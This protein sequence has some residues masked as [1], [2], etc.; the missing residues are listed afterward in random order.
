MAAGAAVSLTTQEDKTNQDGTSLQ[1][2]ECLLLIGTRQD[3]NAFSELYDHYAPRLNGYLIKQGA[4]P[5]MAEELS[6]EALLAVWNKASSYNAKLASPN[7]WIFTIARNLLIDHYRRKSSKNTEALEPYHLDE[8]H[9]DDEHNGNEIGFDATDMGLTQQHLKQALNDLPFLQAQ[10]VY[11]SYYE[12]K[13][14]SE[15]SKDMDLP[16]GTVKSNL[17]LAFQKLRR[18]FGAA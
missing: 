14:H 8:L 17:R 2:A 7:T 16:L 4:V 10:V 3:K 6:Q 18:C 9:H 5:A 11:K 1:W 13:S 15:I 12:G